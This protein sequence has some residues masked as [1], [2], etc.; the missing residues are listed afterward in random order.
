MSQLYLNLTC[1]RNYK[2]RL[3][4]YKSLYLE[5]S[6]SFWSHEGKS[7]AYFHISPFI[8]YNI[9]EQNIDFDSQVFVL[10]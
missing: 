2:V 8:I 6:Y 4:K 3:L 10:E 7:I 5:I 9:H 1:N